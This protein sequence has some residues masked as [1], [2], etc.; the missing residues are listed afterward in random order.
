MAATQLWRHPRPLLRMLCWAPRWTWRR[1]RH[2]RCRCRP[3][4][5]HDGPCPWRSAPDTPGHQ[6]QAALLLLGRPAG[7]RGCL[8]LL[9]LLLLL[10]VVVVV[11]CRHVLSHHPPLLPLPL[12]L[13]Q[14]LL[15]AS[16]CC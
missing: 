1:C 6:A 8:L 7:D 2:A 4:P 9:L 14:L 5:Q 11:C 10:L 13:W 16:L 12:L 15:R 3:P